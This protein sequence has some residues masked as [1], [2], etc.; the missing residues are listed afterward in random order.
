MIILR[1]AEVKDAMEMY[2]Q[3]MESYALDAGMAL[4]CRW[5]P[6]GP[7]VPLNQLDLHLEI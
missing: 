4:Q 5:G 2:F 1:H 6:S 7:T 3:L